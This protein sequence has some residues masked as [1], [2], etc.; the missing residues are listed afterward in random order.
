MREKILLISENREDLELLQWLLGERENI[1][2]SATLFGDEVE[3]LV[4]IKKELWNWTRTI[5]SLGEWGDISSIINYGLKLLKKNI[6]EKK[7]SK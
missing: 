7:S 1:D 4:K 3:V 6:A 5:S 2:M